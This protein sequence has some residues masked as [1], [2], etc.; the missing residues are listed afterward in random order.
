MPGEGRPTVRPRSLSTAGASG[1]LATIVASPHTH[2]L[3]RTL[4]RKLDDNELSHLGDHVFDSLTNLRE[5][6]VPQGCGWCCWRRLWR[7]GGVFGA[8]GRCRPATSKGARCAC[9]QGLGALL[10]RRGNAAVSRAMHQYATPTHHVRSQRAAPQTPRGQP[11]RRVL[12]TDSLHVCE[13]PRRAGEP[14]HRT[15]R[16]V[17]LFHVCLLRV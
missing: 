6:C 14:T 16:N 12:A 2:A 7:A 17:Y 8:E 9:V 3:R 15:E 10:R 13:A 1:Q 4:R 5:L 11:V